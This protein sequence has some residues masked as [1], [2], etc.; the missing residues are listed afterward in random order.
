[1]IRPELYA[2]LPTILHRSFS[3]SLPFLSLSLSL[4]NS[5][6]KISALH[7]LKLRQSSQQIIYTQSEREK[8]VNTIQTIVHG[9]RQVRSFFLLDLVFLHY[10][11]LFYK[12]SVLLF[13][14]CLIS[15][16][17]FFDFILVLLLFCFPPIFPSSALDS[18]GPVDRPP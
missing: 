12:F 5:S 10:F 11:I 16:Y 4:S 18:V 3:P 14:S 9:P 15:C 8:R 17:H 1:M 13:C 7:C 2:S 6:L